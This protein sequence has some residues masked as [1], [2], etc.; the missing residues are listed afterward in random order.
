MTKVLYNTH[1]GIYSIPL[2]VLKRYNELTG[3]DHDVLLTFSDE[4]PRHDPLLVQAFEEYLAEEKNLNNTDV[5]IT[6]IRGNRYRIQEYDGNESVIEPEDEVWI[7]V[8]EGGHE[9]IL[10]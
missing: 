10:N 3:I 5:R 1:W 8:N 6:E 7:E 9:S 2:E 4:I